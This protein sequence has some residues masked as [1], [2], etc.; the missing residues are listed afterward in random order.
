M[1]YFGYSKSLHIEPVEN[2][3]KCYVCLECVVLEY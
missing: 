2:K 3:L 1:N